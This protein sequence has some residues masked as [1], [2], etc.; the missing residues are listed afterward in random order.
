MFRKTIKKRG[1][2]G[3]Y[4]GLEGQLAKGFLSEGIKLTLKDR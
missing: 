2:A 3:M 1:V 4:A